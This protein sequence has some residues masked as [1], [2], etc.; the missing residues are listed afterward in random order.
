MS[1]SSRDFPWYHD[2]DDVDPIGQSP[3]TAEP[4]PLAPGSSAGPSDRIRQLR[5]Q[6]KL[7]ISTGARSGAKA[8]RNSSRKRPHAGD[9]TSLR[10]ARKTTTPGKRKVDTAHVDPEDDADN[11]DVGS[12]FED[13]DDGEDDVEE[14][15]SVQDNC[16]SLFCNKTTIY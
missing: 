13:D 15:L 9:N 8:R 10:K 12:N 2:V 3:S 7:T 6:P 4:S 11:T 1:A 16:V 14:D 5:G